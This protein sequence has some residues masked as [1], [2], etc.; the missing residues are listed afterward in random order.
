MNYHNSGNIDRLARTAWGFGRGGG[1]YR[2]DQ[3]V[4]KR[5]KT[6]LDFLLPPENNS[7]IGP[8]IHR[9]ASSLIES[10]LGIVIAVN[11]TMMPSIKASAEVVDIA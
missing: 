7:I 4:G 8:H 9:A 6:I 1:N 10:S 2:T 5:W 3:K 11:K